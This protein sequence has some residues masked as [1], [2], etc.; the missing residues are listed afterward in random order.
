MSPNS[1]G[2]YL[3]MPAMLAS[4]GVQADITQTAQRMKP[5]LVELRRDFHAHPELSNREERTSRVVAE[6][7]RALGLE[8]RTGIAKHGVVAVLKGG[9]SGPVVAVRADMDA[10]PVQEA[11]NLPFKSQNPGVMHACGHDGHMTIGLGTAEMLAGMRKQ[12]KGTVVF[13]FQPSEEGAPDGERGGADLMIA[14]GALANPKVEAIFGLHVMPG[15]EAGKAGYVPGAAM[16]AIDRFSI[17]IH[18]KMAHGAMP[19]K[20]VDAIVVASE[21]ML[22]LQTIRSRRVDPIQPMVLT[23]GTIQGGSRNNI[24]A[25]KVQMGGT[26]RT[27]SEATRTL[28]KT[29]MKEILSGVTA[30]HGATFELVFADSHPAVFNEPALAERCAV[31]LG[32]ALGSGNSLRVEPWLASEDFALYQQVIP[33]FF[34]FLGVANSAQGITAPLHTA[35]FNLDEEA[36]VAG[37]KGMTTLVLDYLERTSPTAPSQTK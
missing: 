2:F 32:K 1:V 29:A 26:L 13:L 33:G 19:H 5:R 6:R 17:T 3:L 15:L 25:E 11:G 37:V 12:L 34:F 10:L 14:E 30:A 9:Q 4:Q 23:V 28:S 22:A 16:A 27:L 21:C 24:L 18:G 7:L 35:E 20:G 31:S 36:L 8:V